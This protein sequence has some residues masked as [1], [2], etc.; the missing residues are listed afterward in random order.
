MADV[1]TLKTTE[2]TLLGSANAR[3]L[4]YSG[5]TPAVLYGKKLEDFGFSIVTDTME[6]A[7]R[8]HTRVFQLE[9]PSGTESASF[10]TADLRVHLSL[11]RSLTLSSDSSSPATAVTRHKKSGSSLIIARPRS[12]PLESVAARARES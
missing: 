6:R 11:S 1:V 9:L 7:L 12:A 10:S 5:Y 3:R 4:R 8:V 2:R